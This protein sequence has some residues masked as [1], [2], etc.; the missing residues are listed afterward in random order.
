MLMKVM[1]WFWDLVKIGVGGLLALTIAFFVRMPMHDRAIISDLEKFRDIATKWEK[2]QN[3]E[4]GWF[5]L[6]KDRA[7]FNMM[8]EDMFSLLGKHNKDWLS[9]DP[10]TPKNQRAR[11]LVEE[12]NNSI[13]LI[14]RY[15]HI[16]A[17][18]M[19][20]KGH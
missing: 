3:P 6:P 17:K 19:R 12:A 20:R 11:R 1:E 15:G 2:E 4:T 13:Y 9:I 14:R 10:A 18:W 7:V 16:R 5:N 8:F